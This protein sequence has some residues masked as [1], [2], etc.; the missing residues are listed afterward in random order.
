MRAELTKFDPTDAK[1]KE[2]MLDK[3]YEKLNSP[4]PPVK[5]YRRRRTYKCEWNFGD[6]FAYRLES[7]LAK[8]RGLFGRCF[9]IRK[10]DETTWYPGHIIPVVYVKITDD[11]Q[12]PQNAEEY[13]KLEYV[14][15]S[16]TKFKNRFNPINTR[17]PREDIAQKMKINI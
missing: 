17:N 7:E 8:E 3:L 11:D 6:V 9:L 5:K 16:L 12:I 15:V 10:V 2:K 1:Q 4:L 14:Q 13:N